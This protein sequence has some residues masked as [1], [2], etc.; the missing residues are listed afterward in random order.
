[1]I[2]IDAMG[3][4]KAIVKEIIKNEAD[5]I[6]AVKGNQKSLE[7]A[8]KDTIRLEKPCEVTIDEHLGHGRVEQRTCR[9]YSNLSH[10][11]FPEQWKGLRTFIEIESTVFC[12]STKKTTTEKRRYIS[13]LSTNTEK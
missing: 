13:S 6:I 8:I 10:F 1:M 9:S 11:E 12:K 7:T 2:T 5:Y 3:C 4:Q